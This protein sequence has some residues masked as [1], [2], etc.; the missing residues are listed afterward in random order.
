MIAFIHAYKF[1]HFAESNSKKTQ[2]PEKL[3]SFEKVK[4]LLFGVNNPKPHNKNIPTQ[5]YLTL[6][7]K[8]NKEIECW[9]IKNKKSKG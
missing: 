9:L 2:S 7:L 8:S 4:T 3:S 5:K 1:T 6:K